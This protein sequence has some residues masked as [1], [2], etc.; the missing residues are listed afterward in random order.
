MIVVAASMVKV[1]DDAHHHWLSSMLGLHV[2]T[3][4]DMVTISMDIPAYLVMV[5][6]ILACFSLASSVTYTS[7]TNVTSFPTDIP[8]EVTSI[9]LNSNHLG[10]IPSDAINQ[11][12][13][14]EQL[15]ISTNELTNISNINFTGLDDL[16]NL[17]F[18]DNKIM[19]IPPLCNTLPGLEELDLG[20]NLIA[21]LPEFVFENCT[22]IKIL[23][24]DQN[25]FHAINEHSLYGLT[26]LVEF[27]AR[28]NEQLTYVH[29]NI[30]INMT[31]LLIVLFE[32]CGLL[33]HPC[34]PTAMASQGE[35]N[36]DF[37]GNDINMINASE[38][39]G[40][41]TS[42]AIASQSLRL[43][44]MDNAIRSISSAIPV[45]PLLANLVLYGNDIHEFWIGEEPW[46]TS[47]R[48]SVI[49]MCANNITSFPRVDNIAL[50]NSIKYLYLTGNRIT[51]VSNWDL[52]QFPKLYKLTF[53]MNNMVRFLDEPCNTSLVDPDRVNENGNSRI[54]QIRL[55]HNRLTKF[56]NLT[57]HTKI[58]ILTLDHNN[59]RYIT[60]ADVR[61]LT[62]LAN[63][64][65]S[66]NPMISIHFDQ[67]VLP[68][69]KELFLTST[70]IEDIPDLY[71]LSVQGPTTVDLTGSRLATCNASLCWMKGPPDPVG[72]PVIFIEYLM[73]L[74]QQHAG[75]VNN[76]QHLNMLCYDVLKSLSNLF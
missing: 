42:E 32:G 10:D 74:N 76:Y 46:I 50:R 48:L 56:P 62:N 27:H 41:S 13:H 67:P 53:A 30:L 4:S 72:V 38:L 36:I 2:I 6:T 1:N 8:M 61:L 19:V 59:I 23:I 44:F 75:G 43:S 5:A 63:L 9:I 16:R 34:L 45:F 7:S 21:H 54:R 17:N 71:H 24:V 66:G 22:Q 28:L 37:T 31:S 49:D 25:R 33:K 3:A 15:E 73:E 58:A 52:W 47:S 57:S 68:R 12:V 40:L 29:P 51:C 55:W 20:K 14:L 18:H 70:T 39:Y 64:R 11:F 26:S 60:T 69:L 65:L 35:V